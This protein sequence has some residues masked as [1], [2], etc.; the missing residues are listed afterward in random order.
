MKFLLF[1]I[2]D[3]FILQDHFSIITTITSWRNGKI[4]T[5]FINF[6]NRHSIRFMH[7]HNPLFHPEPNNVRLVSYS[8]FINR[9]T[10]KFYHRPKTIDAW[11]LAKPGVMQAVAIASFAFMC[12]H[13]TFLLYGSLKQP[14]EERWARLTHASVFASTL[15]EI[16]YAV[17]GY[18]TFTGFVQG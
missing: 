4:R 16:M 12:H 8:T 5:S 3:F 18:A 14:S 2:L 15:L 17:F 7:N 6:F 1:E 10:Y 11:S 9:L 13:S